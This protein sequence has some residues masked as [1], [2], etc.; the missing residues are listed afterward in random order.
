MSWVKKSCL[1][2]D[3]IAYFGLKG[4]PFGTRYLETGKE[5]QSLFVRTREI[6]SKIDPIADSFVESEPR[7]YVIGGPRGVGKSTTLHYLGER[8]SKEKTVLQSF[9][10]DTPDL[11][12]L[13]DPVYG[14]GANALYQIILGMVKSLS[15]QF[16]TFVDDH[17]GVLSRIAKYVGYDIENRIEIPYEEPREPSFGTLRVG[18]QNLCELLRKTDNKVRSLIGIDNYDKL[19]PNLAIDFLRS[20]HAQGIFELLQSAGASIIL[21]A[22]SDWFE[23]IRGDPLLNYLG[24]PLM[25]RPLNYDECKDL[26]LKRI[27][28]K[29][30]EPNPETAEKMLSS[31][32][33]QHIAT[34]K[35][36]IPRDVLDIARRCMIKAVQK[37]AKVVDKSIVETVLLEERGM[38]SDVYSIISLEPSTKDGYKKLLL[39]RDTC[40]EFSDF[41]NDINDLRMIFESKAR[42]GEATQSAAEINP[43]MIFESKAPVGDLQ[44]LREKGIIRKVPTVIMGEERWVID[45]MVEALLKRMQKEN[46]LEEFI[47]WLTEKANS[48]IVPVLPLKERENRELI[49]EK[50]EGLKGAIEIH[51][52]SNLLSHSSNA[53]EALRLTLDEESDVV[54][55]QFYGKVSDILRNAIYAAY[56]LHRIVDQKLKAGLH[57]MN[58]AQIL[59]FVRS[60][61]IMQETV[62]LGQLLVTCTEVGKGV[63]YIEE[64]PREVFKEVENLLMDLLTYCEA[65]VTKASNLKENAFVPI[66]TS[67][68][69]GKWI[70][71]RV[72][73][74]TQRYFV[75]HLHEVPVSQ[76]LLVGWTYGNKLYANLYGE[77]SVARIQEAETFLWHK[78]YN[79]LPDNVKPAVQNVNL[80]YL[81]GYRFYNSYE[82]ATYFWLWARERRIIVEFVSPESSSL[83][84]LES[85]RE[86]YRWAHDNLLP[87]TYGQPYREIEAVA[88]PRTRSAKMEPGKPYQNIRNFEELVAGL[89]GS[90]NILDVFFDDRAIAVLPELDHQNVN[91][92]RILMGPDHLDDRFKV[93][94]NAFVVEQKTKNIDVHFRVL[95]PEDAGSIHDRYIIDDSKAYNIPPL[96]NIHRK[97]ADIK[98][99]EDRKRTFEYFEIYWNHSRKLDNVSV[100]LPNQVATVQN[101][102]PQRASAVEDTT[103]TE[104]IKIKIEQLESEAS[105]SENHLKHLKNHKNSFP[106]ERLRGMIRKDRAN[107]WQKIRQTDELVKDLEHRLTNP[108]GIYNPDMLS[109]FEQ[110]L[111]QAKNCAA[112]FQAV[113]DDLQK[114]LE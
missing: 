20:D 101:E 48:D 110:N 57:T 41:K 92:L 98:L 65:K 44:R 108:L 80:N 104:T 79:K 17:K 23:K 6:A 69:L 77:A 94:A 58:D 55:S 27:V 37:G 82:L 107:V 34:E 13:R 63:S 102:P 16:P 84:Q 46:K 114:M 78:G 72:R 85:N 32:A 15:H 71:P 42:S 47:D 11:S 106:A 26:I 74:D 67:E 88:V 8:L 68:E 18:L 35:K 5:F 75:A 2:Q 45:P 7:I 59:D 53:F 1:P 9:I 25:L 90:I 109:Q 4:D 52:I 49:K 38:L 76:Y 60:Q 91:Q 21:I 111:K 29:Q 97:L 22:G 54:T 10:L 96:N 81:N 113:Y 70:A 43:R 112:R 83:L 31:D 12:G 66:P 28:S 40:S 64:N 61:R 100:Q 95:Q 36:G 62:R 105:T 33:L 86:G 56:E 99:L 39:Y 73:N 19:E 50:F 103:R 89:R 93:R 14:I 51:L 3:W 30:L 24:T 87:T